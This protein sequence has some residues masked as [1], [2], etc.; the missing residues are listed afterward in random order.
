MAGTAT[1]PRYEL[2]DQFTLTYAPVAPA[3]PG[4][5][6]APATPAKTDHKAKFKAFDAASGDAAYDV[7]ASDPGAENPLTGL[8]VVYVPVGHGLPADANG[9]VELPDATYPKSK[10]DLTPAQF[11]TTVTAPRPSTLAANT[12]YV[13]QTIH[14]YAS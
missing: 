9:F 7:P 4:A 10:V 12:P 14:V 11:G 3:A 6:V 8:I 5:P 2:G 13:G 1:A